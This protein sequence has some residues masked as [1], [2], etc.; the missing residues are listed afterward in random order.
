M[1]CLHRMLSVDVQIYMF[2]V[3]TL[4]G[5][6]VGIAYDFFRAFRRSF[7]VGRELAGLS[8]LL[9]WLVATLLG[10]AGLLLGNWGE[11][12][13]Y[14]F[15]ALGLGIYLYFHLASPVLLGLFCRG[16]RFWG[17]LIGIAARLLT[18]ATRRIRRIAG[19]TGKG[20]VVGG[21]KVS[22]LAGRFLDRL[23]GKRGPKPPAA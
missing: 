4:T 16:F 18:R 14:V 23:P 17:G 12:R 11:L 5:M 22:G 10:V 8:D 3:L 9:F 19:V 20:I 13:L 1:G 7:P 21:R 15:I 2:L 6:G